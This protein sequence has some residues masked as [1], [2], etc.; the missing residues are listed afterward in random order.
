MASLSTTLYYT[1]VHIKE[2]FGVTAIDGG[3]L[4]Q[5]EVQP[6]RRYGL[7]GQYV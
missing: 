4:K 5:L 3:F 6:K 1:V 2:F 7:L